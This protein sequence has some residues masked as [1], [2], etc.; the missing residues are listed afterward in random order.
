MYTNEVFIC[1]NYNILISLLHTN[2]ITKPIYFYIDDKNYS[3]D[4]MKYL[5]LLIDNNYIK[6]FGNETNINKYQLDINNKYCF[7][8]KEINICLVFDKF[9]IEIFD[10]LQLYISNNII[11]KYTNLFYHSTNF[12]KTISLAND[13]PVPYIQ[14]Y[15]NMDLIINF[16]HDTNL[17]NK[18][19]NTITITFNKTDKKLPLNKIDELFSNNKQEILSLGNINLDLFEKEGE[20]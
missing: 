2:Y 16:R 1:N 15:N 8:E 12:Y 17:N 9:C 14:D 20:K 5:S 4:Q 7:K 19:D 10:I 11:N 3:D 6:C 18:E 13:K